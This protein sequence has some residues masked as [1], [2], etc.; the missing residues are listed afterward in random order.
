MRVDSV[1]WDGATCEDVSHAI[2]EIFLSEPWLKL[3]EG[4][5]EYRD[6]LTMLAKAMAILCKDQEDMVKFLAET[7]LK[8]ISD[9]WEQIGRFCR[10][11]L[12][13]FNEKEGSIGIKPKDLFWYTEYKGPDLFDRSMK[14]MIVKSAWWSRQVEDVAR[15]AAALPSLEPQLRKLETLLTQADLDATQLSD[16]AELFSAVKSVVRQA[17]LES[18]TAAIVVTIRSHVHRCL[19]LTDLST[20]CSNKVDAIT[21]LLTVFGHVQGVPSLQ[22]EFVAWATKARQ[23]FLFNTLLMALKTAT[24]DMVDFAQVKKILD[25]SPVAM[26]NANRKNP[27]MLVGIFHFLDKGCRHI[28]HKACSYIHKVARDCTCDLCLH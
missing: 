28:M 23:I 24:A 16:V 5:P 18:M 20:V 15:S 21:K 1:S 7:E 13:A 14:M 27:D 26:W 12:L 4:A 25:D 10:A 9:V 17:E 3:L 22:E 2:V 8:G 11:V 6:Y 19:N